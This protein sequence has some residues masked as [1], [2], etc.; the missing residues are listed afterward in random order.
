MTGVTAM[1]RFLL[2]DHSFYIL[3]V[4]DNA[5]LCVCKPVKRTSEVLTETAD[6]TAGGFCCFVVCV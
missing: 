4:L 6:N 2:A 3:V 5:G 1:W